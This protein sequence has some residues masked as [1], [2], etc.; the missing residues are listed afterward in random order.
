MNCGDNYNYTLNWIKYKKNCSRVEPC[1]APLNKEGVPQNMN[2]RSA[3]FLYF[4]YLSQCFYF[5]TL[6]DI[7]H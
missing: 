5:P 7:V 4:I 6:I 3:I 2:L 1:F